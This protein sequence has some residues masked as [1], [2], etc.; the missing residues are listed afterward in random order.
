MHNPE[1]VAEI[2]ESDSNALRKNVKRDD[3]GS[4]AYPA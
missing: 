3:G 4:A 1:Y 2:E